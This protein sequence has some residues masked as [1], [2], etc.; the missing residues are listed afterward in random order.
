MGGILAAILVALGLT[1][2]VWQRR[3][4][5]VANVLG[6]ET[7]YSD[8]EELKQPPDGGSHVLLALAHFCSIQNLVVSI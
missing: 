1:Y 7:V 3:T 8:D 5:A 4:A 6:L 2:W